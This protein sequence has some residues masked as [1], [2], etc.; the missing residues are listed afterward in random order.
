MTQVQKWRI[1][2]CCGGGE[3]I[4]FRGDMPESLKRNFRGIIKNSSHGLSVPA[5]PENEETVKRILGIN[6]IPMSDLSLYF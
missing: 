1:A 6:H 4:V 5:T 2:R 3:A